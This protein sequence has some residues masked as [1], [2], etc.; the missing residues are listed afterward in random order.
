MNR[1][2]IGVDHLNTTDRGDKKSPYE[3]PSSPEAIERARQSSQQIAEKNAPRLE[4][5]VDAI[6]DAIKREKK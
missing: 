1:F 2:T 5:A 3:T 4:K 6:V